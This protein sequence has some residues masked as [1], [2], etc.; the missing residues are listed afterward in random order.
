MNQ[1]GLRGLALAAL[2]PLALAGMAACTTAPAGAPAAAAAPPSGHVQISRTANGIAHIVAADPEM[3]AYGVAYA[4][5]QD[6]VCQTAEA[7]VTTRAERTPHF[8]AKAI[9]QL[10]L[11]ALPN[12]QI[13]L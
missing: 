8:G 10:G 7:L 1:Q 9:G 4:H 2:L 3:L 13:D 6:N 12:E 11:R 5:A